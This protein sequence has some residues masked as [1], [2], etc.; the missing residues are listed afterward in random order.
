MIF[1]HDDK[2]YHHHRSSSS[3]RSAPCSWL[4]YGNRPPAAYH[5][6]TY[7]TLHTTPPHPT[8]P[9]WRQGRFASTRTRRTASIGTWPPRAP[10]QP[11][12]PA[13]VPSRRLRS[14]RRSWRG[15]RRSWTAHCRHRRCRQSRRLRRPRMR[16]RRPRTPRRNHGRVR[17]RSRRSLKMG[18]GRPERRCRPWS[19]GGLLSTLA[20]RTR[21]ARHPASHAL[22]RHVARRHVARRHVARVTSPT[23]AGRPRSGRIAPLPT[24]ATAAGA[25]RQLPNWNQ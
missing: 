20:C 19:P 12:P 6:A 4:R 3:R 13:Y 14:R 8:P 17:G 1:D 15:R 21:S 24:V 25:P 5:T 7:H 9:S 11:R 16:R 23:A 18:R 10:S 22:P 2:E